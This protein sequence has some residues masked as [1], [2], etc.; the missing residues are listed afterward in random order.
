MI[1][2]AAE[3]S[4]NIKAIDLASQAGGGTGTPHLITIEGATL[5]D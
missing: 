1:S 3:L 4:A 5:T 2:N